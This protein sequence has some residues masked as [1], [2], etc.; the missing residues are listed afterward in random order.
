M[1]SW[2][3]F[4]KKKTLHAKV[5]FLSGVIAIKDC[6]NFTLTEFIL[7]Y[8]MSMCLWGQGVEGYGLK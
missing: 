5:K 4:R 1:K 7:Y 8:E 6:G 3:D 2:L